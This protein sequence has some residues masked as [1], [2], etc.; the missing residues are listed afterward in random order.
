[1]KNEERARRGVE[2]LTDAL[3]SQERGTSRDQTPRPHQGKFI[4]IRS[5]RPASNWEA[6]SS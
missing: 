4:R 3:G 2:L 6:A 5:R 1:M